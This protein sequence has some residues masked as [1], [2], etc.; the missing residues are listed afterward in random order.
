M[1]DAALW[2]YGSIPKPDGGVST[3]VHRLVLRYAEMIAGVIDPYYGSEKKAIRLAHVFPSRPGRLSSLLVRAGLRNLRNAPLLVNGS[4]VD[5][6][7]MLTPFLTR[8][9]RSSALLLHHGNL[10]ANRYPA[11]FE[12]LV[13]AKLIDNFDYVGCMSTR[14]RD[15]YQR[16]GVDCDKLVLIDPYVPISEESGGNTVGAQAKAVLDW[17]ENGADAPLVLAS[18]YAQDYYNHDWVLAYLDRRKNGPAA[19]YLVCTY[20]PTTPCLAMLEAQFERRTDARVVHGL[21]SEEFDQVLSR[22][23]IYVR[24]TQADSFGIAARDALELGLAVIASDACERDPRMLTH[25]VG[26]QHAF[27]ALLDAALESGRFAELANLG[28]EVRPARLS[29]LEFLSKITEAGSNRQD[30]GATC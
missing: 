12:R 20:G 26:D 27:E 25:P 15:Y 8:R 3:F 18:G 22:G 9:T 23:D 7:V 29:I 4:T 16:I 19:R 1:N 14:Q 13:I 6:V 10:A 17:I 28:G 30:W 2:I 5:S 11:A 21:S 24:P